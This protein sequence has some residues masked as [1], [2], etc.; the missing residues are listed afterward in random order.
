MKSNYKFK[1]FT[2][3]KKNYILTLLMTLCL[4]VVSYGQ[5]ML[6]NGGL[7]NWD[8][9]TAPTDWTKAEVLTKSTDAHSGSFSAVRDGGSGT[10][11]LSQTI[12]GITPGESYTL[13]AWYK[14]TAGD[15]KD[16][17]VWSTW[18]NGSTTVYHAGTS[19]NANDDPLRGPNNGYF[20]NNGGVWS[21]YELTVTAPSGV[22][23][24]YFEVRSYSNS[25][26]HWDDLS[27]VKNSSTASLKNNAII[28]FATYPNPVSD[29]IL[30]ISSASG[31]VKNLTIFNLLGKQVLSSSFSGVN[32]NIDVSSINTG[33]YILKVTEEGK[34]A[35]KKLIIR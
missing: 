23:S 14:V 16:A 15:D 13:T 31:S 22:D 35:T 9:D 6:L 24:F 25:T 3:M 20:D 12:T 27:F 21:K 1:T 19:S 28:G 11:D 8:S 4:T 26:T 2:S 30:N 5:E 33:M 34:I 10:K 32:K 7:E 29:G 17:R 18:K